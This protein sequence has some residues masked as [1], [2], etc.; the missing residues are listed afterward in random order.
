MLAYLTVEGSADRQSLAGLF[1]A[2]SSPD[3]ARA[4]L[5]RTLSS[6]RSGIGPDAISANR[7]RVSLQPGHRSDLAD[8]D[9]AI[10]EHLD[11]RSRPR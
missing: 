6:L 1:W 9:A 10:A 11:T 7:D 5:R 4:T 3:R 8:F 2:D